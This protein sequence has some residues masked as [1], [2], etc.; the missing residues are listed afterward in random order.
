MRRKIQISLLILA[1]IGLLV[2]GTSI[3]YFSAE[4]DMN[5]AKF[6][7]TRIK[8]DFAESAKVDAIGGH[9][10][11]REVEWTIENTGDSDV[12]LRAKVIQ[13]VDLEDLGIDGRIGLT[14]LGVDWKKG[15]SEYYYYKNAVAPK[16][17]IKFCI[18][19][20]FD[21]WESVE[22]FPINIE[23]EA[24]QASNNAIRHVWP[25]NPFGI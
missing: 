6:T 25:D 19:V 23:V 21:V 3:A 13:D 15:E 16:E 2:G 8:V 4:D 20:T 22:C 17:Q 5:K 1:L 11:E 24:I 14:A 7:T 12:Y 10:D 18:R 9:T